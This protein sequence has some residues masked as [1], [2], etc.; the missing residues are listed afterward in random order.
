MLSRK[1]EGRE[2]RDVGVKNFLSL[3]ERL[4]E[5][6]QKNALSLDLSPKRREKILR[7]FLLYFK[8]H[9]LPVGM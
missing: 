7:I 2:G 3:W 8:G 9:I 5:G 6:F 1:S 4:G